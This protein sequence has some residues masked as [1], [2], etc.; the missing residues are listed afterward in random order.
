[1]FAGVEVLKKVTPLK[2]GICL[3]KNTGHRPQ[4]HSLDLLTVLSCYML[5]EGSDGFGVLSVPLPP[6]P[7]SQPLTMGAVW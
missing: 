3:K 1:M 5:L 4:D 6:P 7:P 2:H